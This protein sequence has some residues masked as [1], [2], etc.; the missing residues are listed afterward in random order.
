[1]RILLKRVL[2]MKTNTMRKAAFCLDTAMM[3]VLLLEAMKA[4]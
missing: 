3:R 2:R 1:M 4:G